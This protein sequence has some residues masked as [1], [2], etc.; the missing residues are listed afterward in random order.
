MPYSSLCIKLD[1]HNLRVLGLRH[2][3]SVPLH[4]AHTTLLLQFVSVQG[5]FSPPPIRAFS[6]HKQKAQGTSAGI[7][8]MKENFK[9]NL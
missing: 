2:L 9:P 6:W 5:N 3:A 4:M 7:V 1:F 8:A